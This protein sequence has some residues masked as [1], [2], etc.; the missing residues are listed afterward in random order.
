MRKVEIH[1]PNASPD[2]STISP[3]SIN[4]TVN[5]K[6]LTLP[7]SFPEYDC[8]DAQPTCSSPYISFDVDTGLYAFQTSHNHLLCPITYLDKGLQ[9]VHP[10]HCLQMA[11]P[12]K[13]PNHH[14]HRT[15]SLFHMPVIWSR[16]FFGS[17]CLWKGPQGLFLIDGLL[18]KLHTVPVFT[19]P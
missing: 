7:P 12:L 9:E 16:T 4:N 15:D 11:F 19:R 18:C 3:N 10:L 2:L 1:C 8:L 6:W 13:L 5:S 14:L 17:H